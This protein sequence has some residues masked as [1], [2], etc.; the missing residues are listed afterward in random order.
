MRALIALAVA[1]AAAA[2]T[3]AALGTANGLT[4]AATA[5]ACSTLRVSAGPDTFVRQY[6]N[7]GACVSTWTATAAAARATAQ[8]RCRSRGLTGIRFSSCLNR[9]LRATLTTV[10]RASV[11]AMRACSARLNLLGTNAFGAAYGAFG[12]CVLP[13]GTAGVV[14]APLA[15]PPAYMLAFSASPLAGSGVS[16]RGTIRI[17]AH[18]LVLSATLSGAEA[19]QNHPVLI[20]GS[21]GACDASTQAVDRG[22]SIVMDNGAVLVSLNPLHQGGSPISAFLPSAP[23]PFSGRRVLI[24]GKTVNGSYDSAAPVACGTVT[25]P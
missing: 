20:L 9:R 22:G 25:G 5:Q 7:L 12:Q 10:L 3:P 17:N 4:S 16:G 15:G 18:G 11:P 13:K 24:L 1:T 8:S 2:V 19:G 21:T 6:P 23:G 14:H